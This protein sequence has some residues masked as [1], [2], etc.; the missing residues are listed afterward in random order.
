MPQTIHEKFHLFLARN[1][2]RR[3]LRKFMQ[4][5]CCIVVFITTYLLILPGITLEQQTFCGLEEHS[6]SE[7]GCFVS[8]AD[9]SVTHTHTEDCYTRE[10]D[11][12]ICTR[13]VRAGHLH[14]DDC[15]LAGEAPVCAGLHI[16]EDGC[17]A[18]AL[19][20]T[21][22]TQPHSH[23]P[24]CFVSGDLNCSIPEGHLHDERCREP[25]LE[26]TS[27][28]ADHV[29]EDPC[30]S[31]VLVCSHPEQHTHD[32]NCH[33]SVLICTTEEGRAHSHESGCYGSQMELI[34]TQPDSHVHA[35]SCYPQTLICDLPED[36]GH[37]H[38]DDCFSWS[39]VLSCGLE[40]TPTE[41]DIPTDGEAAVCTLEAHSHSLACYA[42]PEADVESRAVWEATL[43]GV[44]RTGDWYQDVLAV[45]ESQLGYTESTRNY[46]VWED[47]SLH[48]YTRYGAWYGVPYGDWCG[49]FVSFC[50][51]YAGVE[52]MPYNYGVRPWIGEL[53]QLG[54]YGTPEDVRPRPGCL[55]FFDWD[56]DGLSDHVGI[57]AEITEATEHMGAEVKT[58]EGNS[59]NCVRYVR[60]RAD[61][62]AIL[63]YSMLP[64]KPRSVVT[65]TA[66]VYTDSTYA[67]LAD[68]QAVITLSGYLPEEARVLAYPVEPESD[69]EILCAYDISIF[70]PD[71]TLYQPSVGEVVNVTIESPHLQ[72]D[73]GDLT[74]YH[75]PEEGS[76]DPVQ[77]N[78]ANGT[79]SFEAEHFSVYAVTRIAEQ[80][81]E[82]TP[83]TTPTG[84]QYHKIKY[85]NREY[86][87]AEYIICASFKINIM[88]SENTV[89]NYYWDNSL[90]LKVTI[91]DDI[92]SDS[93]NSIQFETLEVRKVSIYN[94]TYSIVQP[95][96]RSGNS[97]SF[98]VSGV[99]TNQNYFVVLVKGEAIEEEPVE[100]K[101]NADICWNSTRKITGNTIIDLNGYTLSAN[102]NGPIFE[103]QNGTLTI[104]DTSGGNGNN[105]SLT[106]TI[107]TSIVENEYT[108]KTDEKT[109]KYT[110]IA[111]GG[112]IGGAG[113][114]IRVSGGT[115]N[116][117]DG[118]IHGG[119]GRAIE[120]SG[121]S[122]VNLTGGCI[123]DF[124]G[125]D[126]G[127][128][129]Y[130]SGGSLNI[131][132]D[133][134]IANNHA[135]NYGGGIYTS[136]CN[137]LLSG[138]VISGNT[139]SHSGQIN[140]E[141]GSLSHLHP[142]YGGGGIAL[143]DSSLFVMTGGYLTNNHSLATGYWGGGGAIQTDGSTVTISGGYITGNSA[144]NG[145]G[146]KSR[147]YGNEDTITINNAFICS[148]RATYA[149]GGG[150]SIGGGDNCYISAGYINKNVTDTPNDWGGG[151]VFVSN[152]AYAEIYNALITGNSAGGF[153]GGV[154]GCSTAH[155]YISTNGG[156]A[157]YKNSAQGENMSG[158][159]STKNEDWDFGY[160][161][162][163][164]MEG[165]HYKDLFCA[166]DCEV[167]G[168]MLGGGLAM[169]IGTADGAYVNTDSAGDVIS[170]AKIMGLDSG[171]R[172]AD[173]AK[174]QAAARVYFNGN[175]SNTH[176]GAILCNGRLYMGSPS[177]HVSIVA[178]KAYLDV[179]GKA[180]AF[181]ESN[182]FK[183]VIETEDGEQIS[184]GTSDK[185]G[186]ILVDDLSF[187]N[188]GTYT[189]Y[190]REVPGNDPTIRYD[191]ARYRLRITVG[192][193]GTDF[194][195]SNITVDIRN[196]STQS[197]VNY[198]SSTGE[199]IDLKTPFTNYGGNKPVPVSLQVTKQW[200]CPQRYQ[201]DITV[202]LM[203]TQGGIESDTGLSA[204][205]TASTGWTYTFTDLPVV[206]EAGNSIS[207]S[208]REE[209]PDGFRAEYSQVT[210]DPATNTL[211]AIITNSQ[212][213][214]AMELTKQSNH[215]TPIP[216]KGAVFV[217][218]DSAGNNL[219]FSFDAETGSYIPA[220][221]GSEDL[222]TGTDGKLLISGLPAGTYTLTE[223]S[224]PFG[225]Q[226]AKPK[227]ITLGG[228]NT[229]PHPVTVVDEMMEYE[230]P[231]TG[232]PGTHLYT[233]WGV[234]LT[235]AALLALLSPK[236]TRKN[237]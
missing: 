25:R 152:E 19:V 138:G 210:L 21:L 96:H 74:V 117:E 15:R 188:Q 213:F 171:A 48:G 232:G 193:S 27:C 46:A 81:I 224:A 31:M 9:V 229:D 132:G 236:I 125:V 112:I 34:C 209:V 204:V 10:Q 71:G 212:I 137:V 108:G 169:W 5:L 167:E 105:H 66:V 163:V 185:D 80:K 93:N 161:S 234:L 51:N 228:D 62:P 95:V 76:P 170:C 207:Y 33:S 104:K 87:D 153:G 114:V 6:H 116:I 175:H 122:T 91:T 82:I 35:D 20:C 3:I 225:Y 119:T 148:N 128:A 165:S 67:V 154:A 219:T 162:P 45:A 94:P 231:E 100:E 126:Q 98:S 102:H 64:E 217:L 40:D 168:S 113:P 131:S 196:P 226:L 159:G 179:D 75:I 26:C 11:S 124:S 56:D 180:M 69:L 121:N 115:V 30:Y 189:Y 85:E 181:P 203:K 129:I 118:M 160:N 2:R 140:G 187:W 177:L 38:E 127:G 101:L 149:E 23:G 39:S 183:F 172:A 133:A 12:L 130:I 8:D 186:N 237:L 230:L 44:E 201:Q 157:I 16:H 184:A 190:L 86:D 156:A 173:I 218:S 223:T 155:M 123:Y 24:G 41:T 191:E 146:I 110:V 215:A 134:V 37:S 205:L 14:T 220:E 141:T 147:D 60:Y 65:K 214:Y 211:Q 90:S 139:V 103:V 176:G 73:D 18:P 97:L 166:L 235:A 143:R 72:A 199:S 194:T 111:S 198:S 109:D 83:L 88:E 53:T 178:R 61:D 22:S 144:N 151:G 7:E 192:G 17:Y 55:I 200:D 195:I 89:C 135:S 120:A 197:W 28:D 70:L 84:Q 36:P 164:F 59:S 142:H 4:I 42:D 92:F 32:S 50:L 79:V 174:A 43:S 29:H 206:D 57:V 233:L 1:R 158:S 202:R 13:E 54:L 227:E 99:E 78:A 58:I 68:H 145:G 182:P 208:V 107:M 222:V 150:I 77:T 216:L 221:N 52:G 47:D 136:K 63:G 106:Y 49:M